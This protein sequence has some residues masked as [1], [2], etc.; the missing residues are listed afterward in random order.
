MNRIKIGL[1]TMSI[2]GMLSC[3]KEFLESEPTS[4][5]ANPAAEYKLNGLYPMLVKTGTGGTTGHD[6][7][8]QKGYDIISDM[9]CSDMTLSSS[10]YGWYGGIAEYTDVV[11]YRSTSPN[12]TTWRYYYRL[13]NAANAVIEGLG[14]NS[15]SLVPASAS[16]RHS[17]GQAKGIRAYA[18]FYLLQFYSKE[19]DATADAIPLYLEP[20]SPA[21]AVSKQGEVY[22]SIE[23]DLTHAISLLSDFSRSNKSKMDKNVAKGL[24]AYTYAAQGKNA[25]AAV[26]AQDIINTS[27]YP[28]T[29]RVQTVRMVHS[30]T[31]ATGGGFN[32]LATESWMW[33]YDITEDTGLNLR[34]WWGQVDLFTY[35][36]AW[37]GDLKTMDS[38]LYNSMRSDDIRRR[39]FGAYRGT[40][41]I[42]YNKFF[43]PART[44]GG[45]RTVVTD[46]VF[47]RVDEFHLLAAETLA[48]SGNE[49]A[50]K[51]ILKSYLSNRLTDVSYID[52]LSGTDLQNEIYLNT[53]IEFWGEGKSFLAMKRN[54]ATVTRGTNHLYLSGTTHAYNSDEMYLRIPLSEEQNNPFI[55]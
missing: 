39:Q 17:L 47:M 24:L 45:Q 5:S 10:S 9:M 8:G 43:A 38:N 42:P 19:Y 15:T 6:D 34:S 29:T 14:G 41:Y 7:F 22:Q 1:A 51:T 55:D 18:Y 53:R 23:S 12:Y 2:L 30:G 11:N 44:I 28:I 54:K 52:A 4:F 33:G 26:V 16:D 27:G 32:N 35:S 37:A 50:A 31:E 49:T 25:E 40:S 48:K 3:K 46:Y 13:I 21:K 36:Y 20:N